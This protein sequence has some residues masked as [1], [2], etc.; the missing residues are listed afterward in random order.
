M[1]VEL[2]GSDGVRM[3]MAALQGK[4]DRMFGPKFADMMGAPAS[5]DAA[6]SPP[7]GLT[8]DIGM[9]AV[10]SVAPLNPFGP[11]LETSSPVGRA[12]AEYRALIDQAAR[13]AQIDPLLLEA[14]VSAESDFRPNLVSSAGAM[15]L[16]QLM[17]GTARMLGVTDPM[18]PAQNL[19]G[20]ARYLAQMLR[21]FD[22][23][24]RLALAAYNAGPGAV[25]RHG[26]IPPFRETQ[27][28]VE[29]VL[30]RYD[31]MRTG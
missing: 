29:K 6:P 5:M 4:L 23:D 25:Q 1:R 21:Q 7:S 28:Y 3:R 26:G 10:A 13:S 19:N 9:G 8:G 14:L 11:G 16:A 18:D 31:A 17:P 12:P 27:N 2:Q 22:G 30:S 20:G 15:G 24:R